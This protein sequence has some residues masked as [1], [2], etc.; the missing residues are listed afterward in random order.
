MNPYAA[1][2]IAP[3][4]EQVARIVR[5]AIQA[6]CAPRDLCEHLAYALAVET[7]RHL[8]EESDITGLRHAADALLVAEHEVTRLVADVTAIQMTRRPPDEPD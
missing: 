8:A 1:A 2:L 6:G 7:A 3:Y 4:Q 5:Q